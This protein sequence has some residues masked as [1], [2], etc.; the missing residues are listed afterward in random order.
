MSLKFCL[1][2][3]S[4]S[5]KTTLSQYLEKKYKFELIKISKPLHDFQKYFYS[6]LELKVDIQD[7]ELL[8]FLANKIEAVSEG[9]LG[10]S[11]IK[12]VENSNSKYIINDDCR[13]NSYTYLKENG[14][15]FIKVQTDLKISFRKRK[16]FTE[17]NSLSPL[18]LG[19]DKFKADEVVNNNFSLSK[20]FFQLDKIF[21]KYKE[22]ANE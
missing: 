3:P 13:L 21:K 4:G 6:K 9:W 15:V 20:S 18:E 7:G 16:D 22:T 1:Y 8:Q 2:G 10:K 11:F 12:R 14:F 19:F 5:G 17:A